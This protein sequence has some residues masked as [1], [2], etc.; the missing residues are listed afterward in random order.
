MLSFGVSMTAKNKRGFCYAAV[1]AVSVILD[2]LTK[3]LATAYL[4]PIETFPII[5]DAL[6][7]TYVTNYG[8][9]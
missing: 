8:A 7:L 9:A 5:R 4:K 6:H 3:Q 2:Q 1:I